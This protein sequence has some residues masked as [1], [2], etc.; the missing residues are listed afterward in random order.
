MLNKGNRIPTCFR[1]LV[2]KLKQATGKLGFPGNKIPSEE[3]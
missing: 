2:Q 1:K 3:W